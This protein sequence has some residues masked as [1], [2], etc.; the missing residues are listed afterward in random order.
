MGMGIKME[1]ALLR[2]SSYGTWHMCQQQYYIIYGLGYSS[3]PNKRAVCGTICHKVMEVLAN[4]KKT[5]QDSPKKKKFVFQDEELGP[6]EFTYN[7]L[8]SDKFVG[9]LLDKCYNHYTAS[10]THI[11][12]NYEEDYAFSKLMVDSGLAMNYGAYDP[13]NQNIFKAEQPFDF[14]IDEPWATYTYNGQQYTL[15]IKGT[16]DLIVKEG[17]DV[18]HL[19][20]YKGLALDTPIAKRGGWTTMKDIQ[21][22]DI[23]Y[24]M[25]NRATKVIGKS[26]VKN[27][28]CYK[29]T[30]RSTLNEEESIICD[31][32]HL[33]FMLDGSVKGVKDLI[34]GDLIPY[35]GHDYDKHW[36]VA[37]I[38]PVDSVPTQC[39]KVDS[40]TSTFLCGENMIPTHNTGARKNW[41]T[42][43]E[44]TY[45]KLHDDFQL[46]LYYY[47][48][49]RLF[50]DYKN[51]LVTIIFLRDGGPFTMC[52][53]ED[54]IEKAKAEIKNHL[55][56]VLNTS[57]P[58]LV[59]PFRKDFKCYRLCEFY[60]NKWPGTNQSMCEYVENHV[61]LYGIENTSEKLKKPGFSIGFYSPPGAT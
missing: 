3:K 30:F 53:E 40:P 8:M 36:V 13:R 25:H 11:E 47:A 21:V 51:K 9:E 46:M 27:L 43:E 28:P 42:G 4:C 17:E 7:I 14:T 58:K 50:P 54:T 49:S 16:M 6:F 23:I 24:D 57:N 41:A 60:K 22:G 45:E 29:I 44:K 38:K 10:A 52:Y 61:R 55:E 19:V 20:D 26:E 34:V 37:N 2:S 56:E 1:I 12:F 31:E 15:R 32:E 35:K 18:L 5:M 48:M 39:I 33:W 59:H